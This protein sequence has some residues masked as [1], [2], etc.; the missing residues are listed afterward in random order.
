MVTLQILVL[1]FLVR[2]QVAQLKTIFFGR[3]FFCFR[4]FVFASGSLA[5]PLSWSAWVSDAST[6]T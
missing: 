6:S 1:S 2:I 4:L 3:S 5:L